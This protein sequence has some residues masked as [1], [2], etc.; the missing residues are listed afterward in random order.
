[1]LPGSPLV[2]KAARSGVTG[3]ESSQNWSGLE[4]ISSSSSP[5]YDLVFGAWTVPSVSG[6]IDYS[7][8][9]A[10]E[11]VGIDGDGCTTGAGSDLLQ[12]G[13]ETDIDGFGTTTTYAW[14]E[15]I[16][17]LNYQYGL[18]NLTVSPNDTLWAETFI[19]TDFE[20]PD[21]DISPTPSGTAAYSHHRRCD[22]GQDHGLARILL[23][24]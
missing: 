4:T 16:P 7:G 10:S 23:Y 17:W 5:F 19:G 11:W 6:S 1:M 3:S 12:L 24:R 18:T 20:D 13:S 2:A 14:V 8:L 22:D 9:Y 21:E 15:Y